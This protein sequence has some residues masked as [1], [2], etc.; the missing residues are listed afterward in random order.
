MDW[1]DPPGYRLTADQSRQTRYGW[2]VITSPPKT[3]IAV[4]AVFDWQEA[5]RTMPYQWL[6]TH[7]D[8]PASVGATKALAMQTYKAILERR[9][10]QKLQD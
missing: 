7:P 5:R 3:D 1:P 8:Q 6:N 10:K 2:A 9:R 4:I